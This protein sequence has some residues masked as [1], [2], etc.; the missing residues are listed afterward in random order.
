MQY[1]VLSTIL[2]DGKPIKA[3]EKIDLDETAKATADMLEAGTIE[4]SHKPFAM[5]STP[6]SD[7]LNRE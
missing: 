6:M 4:P 7:R 1:R 5:T 2:A 3:G